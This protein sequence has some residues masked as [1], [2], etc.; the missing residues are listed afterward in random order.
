MSQSQSQFVSNIPNNTLEPVFL[1][2]GSGP[3]LSGNSSGAYVPVFLRDKTS[4][5]SSKKPEEFSLETQNFP[6]LSSNS[7][8]TKVKTT[9]T[10]YSDALKKPKLDNGMPTVVVKHTNTYQEKAQKAQK[11]RKAKM[12]NSIL[13]DYSDSDSDTEYLPVSM[14]TV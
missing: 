12:A 13:D 4:G 7:T 1:G 2:G 10:N 14:Y 6:T 5:D 9:F 8:D 3:S 11:K